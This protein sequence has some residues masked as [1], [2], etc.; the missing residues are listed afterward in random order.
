MWCNP[1][2]HCDIVYKRKGQHSA[3]RVIT[4]GLGCGDDWFTGPLETSHSFTASV[5]LDHEPGQTPWPHES[6][7]A[8]Q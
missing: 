5:Q 4:H 6:R 2:K 1:A 3:E 8:N 7:A